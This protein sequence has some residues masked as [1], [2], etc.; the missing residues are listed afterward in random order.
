MKDRDD[1]TRSR[2]RLGSGSRRSIRAL[3][4]LFGLEGVKLRV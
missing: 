3:P 2:S 4:L 1:V